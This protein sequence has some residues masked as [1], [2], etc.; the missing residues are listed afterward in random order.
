MRLAGAAFGLLL[1]GTAAAGA[2]S[3]DDFNVGI[4]FRKHNQIGESI[5]YL[6]RALAAPDLPAHLRVTALLARGLDYDNQ[7]SSTAAKADYTAAIGLAPKRV[8]AYVYRA[9]TEDDLKAYDAAI[10]DYTSAIALKPAITEFYS[11]RGF[12][13]MNSKRYTE[14]EADFAFYVSVE[15]NDSSGFFQ[16]GFVQWAQGHLDQALA[17]FENAHEQDKTFA[18]AVLWREIVQ[19]SAG[20]SDSTIRH[21]ARRLDHDKWPNPIVD[22]FLGKIKPD[23]VLAAA[24][25]GDAK[26]L[27]GQRCE[28]EFYT[29]EWQL[30]Q[31]DTGDAGSLFS[32][33]AEG[34]PGSYPEKLAANIELGHLKP[35][36]TQ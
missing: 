10:A 17:S 18:Y 35:A 31:K 6:T 21:D 4:A 8:S 1:L 23:E 7:H 16:L 32:R 28:A 12:D 33:A 30:Q 24:E 13:Y 9:G 2:T 22:L 20:K 14:A 29:A 36:A 19:S 5:T 34:C 25:R 26:D 3:Y 27:V 15:S 11:L